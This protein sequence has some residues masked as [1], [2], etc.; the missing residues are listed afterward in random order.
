MDGWKMDIPRADVDLASNWRM[1]RARSPTLLIGARGSGRSTELARLQAH[2]GADR[3]DVSLSERCWDLPRPWTFAHALWTMMSRL[4]YWIRDAKV[5]VPA[6]LDVD[7]KAMLGPFPGAH[8]S[9]AWCEG[10]LEFA[11]DNA[12]GGKGFFFTLS[13][14]GAVNPDAREVAE[15]LTHPDW[16][17]LGAPVI[18]R[19]PIELVAH[20]S[21]FQDWKVI[22]VPNLSIY[23]GV[24]GSIPTAVLKDLRARVP[25]FDDLLDA[26]NG[27]LGRLTALVEEVLFDGLDPEKV[28]HSESIRMSIMLGADDKNRLLEDFE[29]SDYGCGEISDTDTVRYDE[30]GIRL[31]A[32]GVTCISMNGYDGTTNRVHPLIKAVLDRSNST[33]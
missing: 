23:E 22:L 3:V 9:L 31:L 6:H 15:L 13:V 7:Y 8:F 4:A 12:P 1:R 16:Q 28:I 32:S 18:V 20:L 17:K 2:V 14:D 24:A 33:R 19:A 11:W 21:R 27:N 5:K 26:S 25:S 30:Q 29:R 10:L